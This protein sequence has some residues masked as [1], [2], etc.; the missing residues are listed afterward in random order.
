MSGVTKMLWMLNRCV[1]PFLAGC[2]LFTA[3]GA[4]SLG[5]AVTLVGF[6]GLFACIS[7]EIPSRMAASM[8]RTKRSR[9]KMWQLVACAPQE[10]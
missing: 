4:T 3:A 5:A 9:G 6:A 10:A 7:F 8:K 2:C 1:A